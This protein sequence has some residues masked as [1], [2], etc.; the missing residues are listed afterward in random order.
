MLGEL[1]EEAM[2]LIHAAVKRVLRRMREGDDLGT[3]ADAQW[4]M[5]ADP[6]EEEGLIAET[7]QGYE[8]P[9]SQ[10]TSRRVRRETRGSQIKTSLTYKHV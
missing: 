5:L 10:P 1:A 3:G 8:G 4:C 6:W 2:K 9:C 7:V